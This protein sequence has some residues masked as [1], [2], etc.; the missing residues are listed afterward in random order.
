MIWLF[1]SWERRLEARGAEPLVRPVDARQPA[2]DRRPA[3]VLLPVPGADGAVLHDPAVP[4]GLARPVRAGDRAAD[5]AAVDHPAARG[6]RHPAVLPERVA[7]PGGPARAAGDVRRDRRRCWRPWTSAPSAAIVT[8][9]LLL[10]GLGI[11]ALASQLGAVTVSAVPDEQSPEVGGL[12]NT[13]T[14]LG[15]SLGTALAGS[16]LI[17]ALTTS[18]LRGI[19]AEPGRARDR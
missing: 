19:A 9:P 2:A 6:G 3:D 1:L 17:A 11:G 12:Q 16:I 15:A 10:A 7:A 5:P 8:V 13:A 18:F 14:N 4:V